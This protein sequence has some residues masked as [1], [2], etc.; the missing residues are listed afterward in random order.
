MNPS[1]ERNALSLQWAFGFNKDLR[2]GVH[3]LCDETRTALFYA[4]AHSGV[5]YDCATRTQR[6][7]QGHC[8][9]IACAVVSADKRWLVTA[10]AGACLLY[11]SPSPRDA[12][13]SRMP[14]S[15]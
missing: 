1:S 6:L 10:D 15:A 7:L 5:I 2:G 11:T 8:N 4:S 12:T 14:S 13:L 3:S 9:P